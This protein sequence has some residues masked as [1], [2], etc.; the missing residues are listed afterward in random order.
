MEPVRD[1]DDFIEFSDTR[2]E[3]LK[4]LDEILEHKPVSAPFW[5][6]SCFFDIPM[7]VRFV[8]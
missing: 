1:D 2:K 7:L 3:L 8:E 4:R 5:G 6:C